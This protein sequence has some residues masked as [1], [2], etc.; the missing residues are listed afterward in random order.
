MSLLE[1]VRSSCRLSL[2]TGRPAIEDSFAVIPILVAASAE[3]DGEGTL[4][5][6]SV[7]ARFDLPVPAVSHGADLHR[8]PL[9]VVKTISAHDVARD[10]TCVVLLQTVRHRCFARRSLLAVTVNATKQIGIEDSLHPP[11]VKHISI[12][13]DVSWKP[14]SPSIRKDLREPN[15][16]FQNLGLLHDDRSKEI[17]KLY[18]V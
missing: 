10:S 6:L 15:I 4:A 14:N 8:P 9:T 1:M 12:V 3:D 11:C 16:V 7:D 5:W 2:G 17:V 18:L 13:F